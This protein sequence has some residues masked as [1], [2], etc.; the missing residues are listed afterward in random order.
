[1]EVFPIA[2]AKKQGTSIPKHELEALAETLYPAIVEFF[3]SEQGKA[4]FKR[5][6]EE[7]QKNQDNQHNKR[8]IT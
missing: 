4:E 1:M 5:W 3:E 7:Q 2:K 6:Q 8:G